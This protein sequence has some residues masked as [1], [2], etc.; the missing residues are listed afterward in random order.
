MSHCGSLTAH[1]LHT[2]KLAALPVCIVAV[3][4]GLAKRKT[5]WAS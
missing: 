3:Q 2:H 1:S 4:P 5:G